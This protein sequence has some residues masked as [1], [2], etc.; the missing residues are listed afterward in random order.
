VNLRTKPSTS[1][2]STPIS[3][4]YLDILYAVKGEEYTPGNN[5]WYKVL[6]E[7][8]EKYVY[9]SLVNW[10]VAVYDAEGGP[11]KTEKANDNLGF[12]YLTTPG[13]YKFAWCE[14]YPRKDWNQTTWLWSAVEWGTK[15]KVSSSSEPEVA[16][17]GVN[18]VPL[19][20]K[21]TENETTK[22][23][24]Y[25]IPGKTTPPTSAKTRKVSRAEILTQLHK[26]L[27]YLKKV[28]K[29]QSSPFD[30]KSLD[31]KFKEYLKYEAEKYGYKGGHYTYKSDTDWEYNGAWIFNDFGHM[32]CFYKKGTRV[33][34]EYIHTTPNREA[35]SYV[36]GKVYDLSGSHGC[37]HVEPLEIDHMISKGYVGEGN[38]FVGNTL[39]VHKYD[40]DVPITL[41]PV[42]GTISDSRFTVHFYPKLQKDGDG[43]IIV[44]RITK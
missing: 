30:D 8:G 2:V 27:S 34:P 43:R 7:G 11:D 9:S 5:I 38:P 21:Y 12:R 31:T 39:I 16:L 25:Y 13:T 41:K 6:Y 32:S 42:S 29:K 1:S 35:E 10:V 15:L 40:E 26:R 24:S 37:T 4:K 33:M 44:V 14:S 36:F 22:K 19:E 3:N 18:F 20:I 23:R 17:D 28:N